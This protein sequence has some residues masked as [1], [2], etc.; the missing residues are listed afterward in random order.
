MADRI[1]RKRRSWLMSRIPGSNTSPEL[2]L[3]K[4]LFSKGIR[5]WRLHAKDLPGRPDIVFRKLRIAI[6]VDGAFWHGHPY[7]FS[8]GRLSPDWEEKILSNRR[9]DRRV[10]AAL[11]KQGWRVV[12]LWDLD[13]RRRPE[14]QISRVVA[15]LSASLNA[16]ASRTRED[17]RVTLRPQAR[18]GNASH[19]RQQPL[20]PASLAR[21]VRSRRPS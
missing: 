4:A 10:N 15:L 13:L 3:R 8:P 18:V 14:K 11:K 12:R 1:S 17:P 5:G 16:F 19:R 9:R 21:I 2:F 20:S 7:K 6:F